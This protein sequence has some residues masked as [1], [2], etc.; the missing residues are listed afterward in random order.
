MDITDEDRKYILKKLRDRMRDIGMDDIQDTDDARRICQN[1]NTDSPSDDDTE[2]EKTT[3]YSSYKDLVNDVCT[4][5]SKG[6]ITQTIKKINIILQK[7]K[8]NKDQIP[9]ITHC[10]QAKLTVTEYFIL[11]ISVYTNLIKQGSLPSAA[12]VELLVET[13]LLNWY[14]ACILLYDKSSKLFKQEFI[15]VDKDKGGICVNPKYLKLFL[16]M[17]ENFCAQPEDV[18]C[19]TTTAY[20]QNLDLNPLD[21]YTKLNEYIIGQDAVKR[22]ICST[23]YEHV[24]K[25]KLNKDKK[26]R[27][28]KTCTMLIGPTGVGKTYICQTMAKLLNIPVYIAD[29]SNLTAAGYVGLKVEDIFLSLKNKIPSM[30]NNVFPTSIIY[31][32]EIDKIATQ[33]S[34]RQIDIGGKSIQEELL[35]TLEN[36][37]Y[38][39]SGGS[40]GVR[41]TFDISNVLF[42]VGGAFS[43]LEHIIKCRT[44]NK[45]EKVIGYNITSDNFKEDQKIV[46]TLKNVT[47]NDL[48]AYGFMP[49]FMG[50]FTNICVLDSLTKDDLLKI[51]TSSQ[52]NLITQY[53][54]VWN[55][56]GVTLNFNEEVFEYIVNEALKNNTGARGIRNV[57][58]NALNK[59]FFNVLETK[60]KE[61]TANLQIFK[62]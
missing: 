47:V 7:A 31:I 55:A 53:K 13:S 58:S 14:D 29:A 1:S 56:A 17:D 49:E 62:E 23:I 30:E 51:L 42:I 24:L 3:T 35:K 19:E 54:E 25:C 8:A 2:S 22:S 40:K 39:S 34:D 48:I 27:L 16:N 37:T 20:T 45:K 33:P 61:F 9:F 18:S 11:F 15:Y 10:E 4:L 60:T 36:T 46:N 50:R 38:T 21:I 5:F 41:E 59:T 43:G 32:D 44:E 52:N 57:L 28:D 6:K 12:L 26:D